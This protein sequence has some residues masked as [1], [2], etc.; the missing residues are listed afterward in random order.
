VTGRQRRQP[1]LASMLSALVA[2][3]S[4][5]AQMRAEIRRIRR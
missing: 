1:T 4:A 5:I 2:A 3:A